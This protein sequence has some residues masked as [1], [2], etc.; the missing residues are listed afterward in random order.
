ML[1]NSRQVGAM[2]RSVLERSLCKEGGMKEKR[3][4]ERCVDKLLGSRGG[5]GRGEVRPCL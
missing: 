4:P 1:R 2:Q 3:V 5:A